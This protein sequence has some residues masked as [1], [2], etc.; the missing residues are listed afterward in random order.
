[1]QWGAPEWQARQW[2]WIQRL[3][4]QL[5]TPRLV[6]SFSPLPVR[7]Q[8]S[9]HRI[10]NMKGTVFQP[11]MLQLNLDNINRLPHSKYPNRKSQGMCWCGTRTHDFLRARQT[12]KPLG[13]RPPWINRSETDVHTVLLWIELGIH[14]EHYKHH[15]HLTQ[16]LEQEINYFTLMTGKAMGY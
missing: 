7:H 6:L 11:R 3:G 4:H 2:D 5:Y 8:R 9:N 14:G 10:V 1:M 16:T 12:P 13:H 15:I